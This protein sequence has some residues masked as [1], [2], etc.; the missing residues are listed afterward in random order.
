MLPDN[1]FHINLTQDGSNESVLRED[2]LRP[3]YEAALRSV[4]NLFLPGL[5][6]TWI[7]KFNIRPPGPVLPSGLHTLTHW[8]FLSIS[9]CRGYNSIQLWGQGSL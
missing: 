2:H 3:T 8:S 7:N 1:T 5:P 9:S 6:W 4:E